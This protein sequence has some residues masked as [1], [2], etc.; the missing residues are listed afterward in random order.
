M[1]RVS[2]SSTINRALSFKTEVCGFV[3]G[4]A[5]RKGE[6]PLIKKLK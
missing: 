3:T 2:G 4:R 6:K 1:D 5:L